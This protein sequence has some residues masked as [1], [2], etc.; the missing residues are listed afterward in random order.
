MTVIVDAVDIVYEALVSFC[1][2]LQYTV[3]GVVAVSVKVI[4]TPYV[5]AAMVAGLSK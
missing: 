3:T 2:L 4:D 1:P 5:V